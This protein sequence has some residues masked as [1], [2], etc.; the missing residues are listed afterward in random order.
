MARTASSCT[1]VCQPPDQPPAELVRR[2]AEL[3]A[4]VAPAATTSVVPSATSYV[5][6]SAVSVRSVSESADV[7]NPLAPVAVASKSSVPVAAPSTTRVA[8]ATVSPSKTADVLNPLAPASVSTPAPSTSS[9]ASVP[10]VSPSSAVNATASPSKTVTVAAAS[11]ARTANARPSLGVSQS[12]VARFLAIA[13][14]GGAVGAFIGYKR[15]ESLVGILGYGVGGA[16]I[17]A[18]VG[19]RME[20]RQ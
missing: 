9:K 16:L 17:T 15:K 1:I 11:T 13:G 12:E 7:M 8:S 2:L 14:I 18:F 3:R 10:S 4:E 6:P 5:S 19:S 20:S